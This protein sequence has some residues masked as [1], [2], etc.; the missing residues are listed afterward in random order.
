MVRELISFGIHRNLHL[1]SQ[2]R[3]GCRGRD[4]LRKPMGTSGR[5]DSRVD[6]V[7]YFSLVL[8][9]GFIIVGHFPWQPDRGLSAQAAFVS[10]VFHGFLGIV[11]RIIAL[12]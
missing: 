10:R 7:P 6:P 5:T 3:A 8:H 2:R 9:G 4:N 11:S 1:D 12:W